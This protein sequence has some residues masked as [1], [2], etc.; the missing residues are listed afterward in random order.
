MNYQERELIH[1]LML[2]HSSSIFQIAYRR[3]G[4]WHLAED[5]VQ[6][7]FLTACWNVEKVRTSENPY[8]WLLKTL[9]N[10]ILRELDKSYHKKE[11]YGYPSDGYTEIELPMDL[12]LPRELNAQERDMILLRVNHRLSYKELA[13]YYGITETACRQR[14]SR[15]FSKCRK[16]METEAPK[17]S[18]KK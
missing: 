1:A 12:Y 6:E 7:A 13:E 14:L 2:K 11:I 8:A 10:L 9:N 3:L 16:Y 18:G 4:D 15:L 5:I 17:V